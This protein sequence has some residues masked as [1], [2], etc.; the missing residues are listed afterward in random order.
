MSQMNNC[1]CSTEKETQYVSS[2]QT[3]CVTSEYNGE[4]AKCI[5]WLLM[6]DN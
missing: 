4:E 6:S 5:E 3:K 2:E 1:E